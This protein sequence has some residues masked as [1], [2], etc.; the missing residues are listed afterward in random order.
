M[1]FI[2]ATTTTIIIIIIIISIINIIII[3]SGIIDHLV[4]CAG[5]VGAAGARGHLR[6]SS[7]KNIRIQ[8]YNSYNI[9]M[10]MFIK[11]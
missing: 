9:K 11:T 4:L 6:Q 1:M 5:V 2:I 7:V 8:A 3:T 10:Y